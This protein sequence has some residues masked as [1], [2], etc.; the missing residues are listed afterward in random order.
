VATLTSQLYN[1][2][3]HKVQWRGINNLGRPVGTGMYIYQM[4][5]RGFVKSEK[6]ILMK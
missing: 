1:A 5:S 2:G 3:Y 4:R 6:M